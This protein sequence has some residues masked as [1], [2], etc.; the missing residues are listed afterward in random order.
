MPLPDVDLDSLGLPAVDSG[1][2]SD[3]KFD[4]PEAKPNKDSAPR[5][6]RPPGRV[7]LKSRLEES[8]KG[9]GMLVMVADPFCGGTVFVQAGELAAALDAAAKENAALR[10]FLENFLK[11]GT[12]G[13]LF[14]VAW[15]IALP[16]L[17]H[18]TSVIPAAYA[19]QV[20]AEIAT[21]I[22]AETGVDLFTP[23]PN[24]DETEPPADAD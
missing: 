23:V 19:D 22:K 4:V 14:A 17:A 1:N 21:K 5:R 8:F 24:G 20:T 12:W 10:K 15:G 9:F 16:V 2:A 7:A 3:L 13:Q 11:V 18:H 6:G